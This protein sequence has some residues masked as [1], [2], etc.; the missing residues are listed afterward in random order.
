MLLD[1]ELVLGIDRHLRI[2]ADGRLAMRHHRARVGIGKRDL[3]LAAGLQL[4][5]HRLA[6]LAPLTHLGDLGR[7]RLGR[8]DTTVIL[9][10]VDIVQLRQIALQSLV[11]RLEVRLQFRPCEVARLAVHRL[12]PRAIHRQQFAPEQIELTA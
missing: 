3:A 7:K 8:P 1:D 4:V 11:G 9:A 2:V 6:D 12:Q 5:Q 10:A